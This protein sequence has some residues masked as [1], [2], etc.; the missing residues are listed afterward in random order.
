MIVTTAKK[1]TSTLR[2]FKLRMFDRQDTNGFNSHSSMGCDN[3]A[4]SESTATDVSIHTPTWGVTIQ[5]QSFAL[6]AKCFNPHTHMGCDLLVQVGL[7][8]CPGFNPHTHMGC[9]L[10]IS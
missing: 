3:A 5:D 7:L 1:C 10:L 4:A 8:F 6:R 2:F 9:D